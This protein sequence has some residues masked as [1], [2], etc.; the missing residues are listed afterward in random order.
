MHVKRWM[1]DPKAEDTMVPIL[2]CGGMGGV[3]RTFGDGA[4]SHDEVIETAVRGQ[5]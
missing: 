4:I 1:S 3:T 5:L 2:L